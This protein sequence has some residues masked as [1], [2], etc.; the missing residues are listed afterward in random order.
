MNELTKI[1]LRILPFLVVILVISIKIRKGDFSKE[2]L[3]I[4]KP[5]SNFKAFGWWLFFLVFCILTELLLYKFN[6]LTL[7]SYTFDLKTSLL[8]IFG[9]LI[10]APIAEELF[11]RGLLLS[12]LIQFKINKHAAIFLISGFF[13]LLHSFAFEQTLA[14]AIGIAQVFIDA[15][16]FGYARITTKSVY[17]SVIM[18]ITGNLIA[19]A[20]MYLL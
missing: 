4:R 11:F 6:L 7:K 13:V 1:L 2:E 10:L 16:L 15:T 5:D 3:G 20:E 9:M 17:T 12:K 19:V 14:S 18:H 8:K